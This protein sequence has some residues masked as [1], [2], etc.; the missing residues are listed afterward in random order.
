[1]ELRKDYILERWVYLATDRKKRPKEFR[2]EEQKQD[3]AVCFF[4][5]GN[6]HLTPPEIGRIEE[7]SRWKIRWFP[8]KFPAVKQEGNPNI[9]TDN[10]FFT[11]SAGY[12]KHEVIAETPD[13]EKQLW[14]L[15]KEHLKQVLGV[16]KQRIDDISREPGVRY[17]LVFKN[18]GREGGTSLVHT[19]TQV[20]GI[21]LVPPLV[22]EEVEASARFENCPYCSIIETERKSLRRCFENRTF[23]AFSPYASRFNFEIW[24]FPKR[25]VTTMAELNENELDDLADM[26]RSILTKLKELNAPYNFFLHYA[27]Q[28]KDLHMHIEVTPRFATWAGFELAS[29]AIINSVSPE[30]AARFYRGEDD[31]SE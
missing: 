29:D 28:G 4:C 2:K 12:G 10:T 15:P 16:Y 5:P 9:W 30:D 22:K 24:I 20:T 18:H 13:H 26:M 17:V 19:H 25:H 21:N 23:L 7:N 31:I 3:S 6:E 11:Y 27:P 14:D 1:M 8:N